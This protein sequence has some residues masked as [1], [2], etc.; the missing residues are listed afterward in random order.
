M[1]FG[2][3]L[4]RKIARPY[5]AGDKKTTQ[6]STEIIVEDDDSLQNLTP[7]TRH[8]LTSNVP[9]YHAFDYLLLLS[10]LYRGE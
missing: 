7:K 8:P 4:G 9:T 6:L 2:L 10:P 3:E 1:I 5:T